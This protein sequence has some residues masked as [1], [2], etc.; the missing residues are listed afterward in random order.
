M[1]YTL[2]YYLQLSNVSEMLKNTLPRGEDQGV[3]YGRDRLGYGQLFGAG[4]G[5]IDDASL[6]I[7]VQGHQSVSDW[8]TEA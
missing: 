3:A 8:C 2:L 7:T 6:L 5:G 1:T 4:V